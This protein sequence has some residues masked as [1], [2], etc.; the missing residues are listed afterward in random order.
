MSLS[1]LK[2]S[3][4]QTMPRSWRQVLR[5]VKRLP[6]LVRD[7]WSD[8]R[9]YALRSS[10][11]GIEEHRE[12]Q[13]STI[14]ATYH[15]LE[16][17]LSLRA[18]RPGFGRP[19]VEKLIGLVDAYLLR[20]G[21]DDFIQVPVNV[22]SRYCAFN[23]EHGA[24]D[25]TVEQ[26]TQ[27]LIG[28]SEQGKQRDPRGGVISV[29][30]EHFL[31]ATREVREEFFT[32]RHT[33]RQWD[34]RPV[35]PELLEAA[36]RAAQK[37][38]G[39]CNRQCAR[40]LAISDRELIRRTLEIQAGARGFADDVPLLL[41]ISADLSTFNGSG[42]RYQGWI[43]GGMFAMSLLLG[44]HWQG[45]GAC[46]LNWSKTA[47]DDRRMRAH[48]ELDADRLIIMFIAVGHL[49]ERLNVAESV[50]RPLS[51]VLEWRT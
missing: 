31:S 11:L 3:I 50:R 45:L 21:A 23:K 16:K 32:H 10:M 36:I 19:V 6:P 42:E 29:E 37:S 5:G 34:Q 24:L 46:C 17:G 4:M 13:R 48:L 26:R 22:L 35:E 14:I 30:R 15:N 38:P 39:V 41:C 9:R 49:P 8:T 2:S 1:G 47:E 43:D 40:V 12:R 18:P 7:A 33:V 25:P 51:E 44:L 27:S 28:R 20:Y